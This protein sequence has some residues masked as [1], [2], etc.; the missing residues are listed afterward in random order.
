MKVIHCLEELTPVY[1]RPIVT[2]G[3]FD[4]VHLGHQLLMHDLVVRAAKIGGTPTVITFHPHPLQ[5][6]APNNAPQQIQTLG[7]KLATIES[8]GIALVIVIPFDMQLAQTNA[9][10]FAAQTLWKK[11]HPQEIYVGPNFA[12]GHRRQ[13]SFKL[14]K[15]FGE[16]MGFWVGK[17]HQVQFRGSR[18]SS[19]SIRQA[20]ISGQV[21]LA[22]RL[23]A[24]PF[25]LEGSIIPG[26][27]TGTVLRVPTAN[28]QT[29]NELI[30]RR[31]VYVTLLSLGGRR[32][33]GVT[34][35]GV[36]PTVSS[37]GAAASPSIETHIL[38]FE[39][40]IY[41]NKVDLEFLVRLREERRFPSTEYL[42]SQIQKDVQR[43]R[44]FFKW[45]EREVPT[46]LGQKAGVPS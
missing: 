24:R 34:N 14:L 46:F 15:E 19:T 16:E 33:R 37:G 10:D 36:R 9:R 3:N 35:I 30:P 2:I 42:V 6:L 23:L 40:N 20:L 8:L 27:S 13:G 41:G 11:L 17:I 1:A 18:V 31:G 7:Q 21:G 44:R 32:Y 29:P 25:A 45:L 26:T 39:Q 43:A 22:R 4:G 38:D 12:F 28:L 5:V